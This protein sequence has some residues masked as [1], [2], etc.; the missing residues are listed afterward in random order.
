MRTAAYYLMLVMVFTLPWEGVLDLPGAGSLS[1][2]VGLLVAA[3]WVVAVVVTGQ[4]R[5]PRAAHLFGL[6]FVLWN[7]CSLI[8]T[9]DGP[10][11][12][13]RVL[14]YV[15]LLGLTMVI[16]D[17]VTTLGALTK[18]L[19]AYLTGC[20]VTAVSL[21]V[22]YVT[23]GEAAETHGRV[24]VGSFHPNDVA[25]IVALGV[26]VAAY[27]IVAPRTGRWHYL[28]VAFATLYLPIAGFA[29]LV[30]G[31]RT[32]IAALIPGIAFLGYRLARRRP[33]LA[34]GSLA[35]LA[36]LTV[37]A[38]PLAPERVRARLAETDS[39]IQS[40][41]L[42]D[43]GAVWA[44]ADPS[45]R[46]QPTAG[47]GRRRVPRGCGR[48]QQGGA[49]LCPVPAR[50]GGCDRVRTVHRHAHRRRALSGKGDATAQR[51]VARR[52]QRVDVGR[53]AAQ[54]GVPEADVVLHRAHGRQRI[55]RRVATRRQPRPQRRLIGRGAP[56]SP[57]SRDGRPLVI[58]LCGLPG[59]GKTTVAGELVSCLAD[60]GVAARVVDRHVSADVS[61][62]VRLARK[63]T[64][65]AR[66]VAADP[67]REVAAARLLGSG[68]SNR[69]DTIALPVQWWVAKDVLA[70]SRLLSGRGGR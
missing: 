23:M 58:E 22:S 17:T 68:Q 66:V 57:A 40:G 43:R 4:V 44:E 65:L 35:V 42:N 53:P 33:S 50:R 52:L 10:A 67:G 56:M 2:L 64:T 20:Y 62:A 54:L 27:L 55:S 12:Q 49:Q 7:A 11:T 59:A 41:D 24:T 69:R 25:M 31:S 36:G 5:E 45:H 51:D 61:R 60:H 30:T 34:V 9:T 37:A 14:T 63:A 48:G 6:L 8:W 21:L 26:P 13:E 39:A 15:Q 47:R 3:T 46:R 19:L 1:K 16:W 32:G 70:R 38:L 29:V 28:R 18:T